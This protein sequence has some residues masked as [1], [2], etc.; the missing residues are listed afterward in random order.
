M[1]LGSLLYASTPVSALEPARGLD[2]I[3]TIVV[4]YAENR[5]FDHLYGL[6][7]GA[8]GL[9][10]VT[11]E[12]AAQHDR[13]GSILMELP[14]VWGG[15]TARGVVPPVT[16]AQTQHLPNSPFA[17]DDPQGFN[18]GLD[19][20]TQTP[21]HLFYQNI[22]Q[23]NG[24]K[25]NKFVA[26]ADKGA[27]PMGYYITNEKNLPLWRVAREYTLADN[28]FMGAFG[29]SYLNHFWLVC[30]CT[31]KYPNADQSPAKG[32]ISVVEPD[33]MSLKLAD[34]SPRSALDGPPKFVRDGA[35]TPDFYSVNTMQP[36][37][38][39]SAV[40]PAND[41]NPLYADPASGS[42]LPP[43]GEETIGDLLSAKG[44]GWA[45]YAGAWLATLEGL[46]F[47]PPPIFQYHHQPFN[48]FA[49][50][51]PG[52]AARAEHLRDGGIN[53][54][55]FISTIDAGTL[56][57]V[58]FYKPQGNLNEH[59]AY[60]DVLL[61]DRHILDVVNH[62]EKSPQWNHMLVV[63]TYDENGSGTTSRRPRPTAGDRARACRQSS[64]RPSPSAATSTTRSMIRPR[65]CA[66]SP[67]A[68]AC[69]TCRASLSAT[70]HCRRTRALRSAILPMRSTCR[71]ANRV[72]GRGPSYCL[73]G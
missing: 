46:K 50:W 69:R 35:L 6:F 15:L 30:A 71:P 60:A 40:K 33:G 36:P 65:S 42:I 58:A 12:M 49:A 63:I 70:P 22:M 23:I 29:G 52:T 4:I 38:Q 68:S 19:I 11:P 57:P 10:N 55:A 2:Q 13:D 20:I 32:Q 16:E 51:A 56:P 8:N 53:G 41:G 62:L 47:T 45:W 43:Q 17:I 67:A 1:V 18:A 31:P 37:Y 34:N 24:G 21:W 61:G 73:T 7:P 5:G 54:E 72:A 44:I 3:E 66:S 59:P 39:P 48:Y 64:P 28:F 27:L 26:F 9:R 14:P 25:N